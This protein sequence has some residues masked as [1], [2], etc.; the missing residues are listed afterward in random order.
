MIIG[1]AG[2]KKISTTI[3]K[4]KSGA[5]INAVSEAK[6]KLSADKNIEYVGSGFVKNDKVVHFDH[7]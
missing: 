5:E 2:G 7:H 1:S 6:N 4:L 3:C